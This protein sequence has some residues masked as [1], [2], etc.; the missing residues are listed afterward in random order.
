MHSYN[1][2][3]ITV[4]FP[5]ASYNHFSRT[6]WKTLSSVVQNACL[7]VHYL[8]IVERMC[9]GNVFTGRLP[10]NRYTRHNIDILKLIKTGKIVIHASSLVEYCCVP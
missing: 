4:V 7:L 3:S 6:S 2:V 9:C 10:S 1:F 5:N 8:A